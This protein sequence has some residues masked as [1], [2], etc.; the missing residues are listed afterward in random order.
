MGMYTINEHD[1]YTE[2]WNNDDGYPTHGVDG[3]VFDCLDYAGWALKP[4]YWI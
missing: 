2:V 4:S 1:R 3:N